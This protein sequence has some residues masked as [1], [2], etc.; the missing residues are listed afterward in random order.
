M[1]RGCLALMLLAL[2]AS[3]SLAGRNANGAM[4]VHVY[5][6]ITY[7]VTN[8]CSDLPLP[9]RC[10]DLVPQTYTTPD[11]RPVTVWVVG[12]FPPGSSPGITA[13]QFGVYHDL[14]SGYFETFAPCGPGA[15][16][17][18]DATFPDESGTGVAVAYGSA[19]YPVSPVKLYWFVMYG[20]ADTFMRIGEYPH[21]VPP[22][23][24][25][26]DDGSPPVIDNCFMF[27]T[28]R[29]GSP[30]TNECPTTC[31]MGACCFYDCHCEVLIDEDC[32]AN[33]GVYMGDA[34]TCT[35][36]PCPCP[37]GACCFPDGS[38][39][40]TVQYT[41][42]EQGGVWHFSVP[43][44]PNPCEQ[45]PQA[46]CFCDGSCMNLAV[47]DCIAQSGEPEGYGTNC[48]SFQ[49]PSS[50][51]GACCHGE[52][53]TVMPA[54][55]CAAT[56]GVFYEGADCEPNPCLPSP[57]KKTTWGQIKGAYR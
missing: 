12:V 53:C 17:I 4:V 55:C 24:Q 11:E 36:N 48:D 56:G 34:M 49:C 38:C 10:E 22:R 42:E 32:A 46:C 26:A 50:P 45:P 30:G 18:P 44:T 1:R 16:Q 25:W 28:F 3:P 20:L 41:C 21:V 57:S 31:C 47:D 54:T 9:A 33:G 6:Q 15:L 19:V 14:P 27:G 7:C 52:D 35:P 51:M 8:W 29:W 13:Y 2:C 5:D 37:T 23:A 43:C 39:Q 40:Y